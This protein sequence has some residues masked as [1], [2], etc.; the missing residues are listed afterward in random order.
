VRLRRDE[1]VKHVPC[2][3]NGRKLALAAD[4]VDERIAHYKYRARHV[5][6]DDCHGNNEVFDV[7]KRYLAKA[8]SLFKQRLGYLRLPPWSF[9]RC[10]T[11]AGAAEFM[12]QVRSVPWDKHDPLTRQLADTLGGAYRETSTGRGRA[13]GFGSRT[14]TLESGFH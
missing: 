5:T 14:Q 1:G 13:P 3:W 11:V 2:W 4:F 7:T 8:A 10:D 12:E 6:I 9:A